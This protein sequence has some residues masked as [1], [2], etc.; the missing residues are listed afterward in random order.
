[1]KQSTP[2]ADPLRGRIPFRFG[3]LLM[4][5]L[6]QSLLA[7]AA[8]AHGYMT[9]P[10]SRAVEQMKGPEK[11]WPIA[12][13]K[14]ELRREPCLGLKFNRKFTEVEPGPLQLK[15]QFPDGENHAG[16]CYAYLLDP[17]KPGHK[18]QIGEMRNCA[19]SAHA[20]PGKKGEDILGY[21]P[22][23][24]PRELPCDPSHCVLQ[25]VWIATQMGPTNPEHYEHYDSCADLHITGSEKETAK[26]APVP[27]P[28]PVAATPPV[29]TPSVA[30]PPPPSPP[31]AAT[32]PPLTSPAAAARPAPP[33][34][35]AAPPP[36]LQPPAAVLAPVSPP[37][38]L[39]PDIAVGE[40][41]VRQMI[42]DATVDGGA[43]KET[44][45]LASRRRIE[46]LNLG[47]SLPS[48]TQGRARA[49]N[50]RGVE[51]LRSG[52]VAE[53]IKAFEAAYRLNST[54]AEIVANLGY[55]HF[56]HYDA[57]A[58]EPL[59]VLAL[60]FEPGR[61]MSWANL[62]QSQAKQGKVGEA[63][64]SWALFYRFSQN[65]DA[66]IQFLKKM[67]LD[68]DSNMREAA[69]QALQA[70]TKIASVRPAGSQGKQ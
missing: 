31:A 29:P 59:L 61:S 58:A 30:A 35:A 16:Y 38:A 43:G 20:D 54:N 46:Q 11:S 22:V 37:V 5:G 23:T 45:I 49:E 42:A 9:Y 51:F 7:T 57:R 52:Q 10:R 39:H 25:W 2:S 48:G 60:V 62:G 4:M 13:A 1:M 33:A 36:P 56:R 40:K 67:A 15:L 6:S 19:S 44:A 66:T 68:E 18:V 69:K 24:I 47:K 26:P 27:L 8:Y 63:V 3:L 41:Y 70:T 53:A 14:E 32:A 28:S 64:A 50:K 34:S 17:L 55:A 21:M 12:G 65:R